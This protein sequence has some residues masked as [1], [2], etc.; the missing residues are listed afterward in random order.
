MVVSYCL[1]RK[2][3]THNL[4]SIHSATLAFRRHYGT[5]FSIL[6]RVHHLN[7]R[8][9]HAPTAHLFH[10]AHRIQRSALGA[11]GGFDRS[12][13]VRNILAPKIYVKMQIFTCRRNLKWK[14]CVGMVS[15]KLKNPTLPFRACSNACYDVTTSHFASKREKRRSRSFRWQIDSVTHLTP[16][17]LIEKH[18]RRP[19][20]RLPLIWLAI[21]GIA[22]ALSEC[23]SFELFTSAVVALIR[24]YVENALHMKITFSLSIFAAEAAGKEKE[25]QM[26]TVTFRREK[27]LRLIHVCDMMSAIPSGN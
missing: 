20:G 17:R 18:L 6:C 3:S 22:V 5:H 14:V 7:M 15:G 21:H 8:R 16:C 13:N 25:N 10:C 27:W 1:C 26:K 4:S 19:S 12:G 9:K 11:R 23:R 2:H 24:R